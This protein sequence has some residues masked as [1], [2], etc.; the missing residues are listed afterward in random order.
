MYSKYINR[1]SLFSFSVMDSVMGQ[2]LITITLSQSIIV[3]TSN[4]LFLNSTC[5]VTDGFCP[6]YEYKYNI[7]SLLALFLLSINY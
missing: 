5:S 3:A 4:F 2:A 6:L 7:H 1:L